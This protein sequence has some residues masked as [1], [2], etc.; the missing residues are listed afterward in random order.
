MQMIKE[1]MRNE[2]PIDKNA[3]LEMF[4]NI[5]SYP[6]ANPSTV[7]SLINHELPVS[8]ENIV[9]FENYVNDES[10]ILRE[11]SNIAYEVSDFIG[12]SISSSEST[13][14]DSGSNPSDMTTNINQMKDT[15][16]SILNLKSLVKMI[17]N[18]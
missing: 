5:N 7:V 15:M 18:K 14:G 16:L 17:Y 9:Q 10:S 12:Q 13:I 11:L 6:Q 8:N 1:M 3:V 2:M 4:K